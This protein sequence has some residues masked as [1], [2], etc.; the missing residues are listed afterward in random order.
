MFRKDVN[1]RAFL[2]PTIIVEHG[3]GLFGEIYY[4]STPRLE[5]LYGWH[6]LF[7]PSAF[8]DLYFPPAPREMSLELT[9]FQRSNLLTNSTGVLCELADK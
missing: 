1:C 8:G 7:A 6:L 3:G 4:L 2:S 5:T 9:S